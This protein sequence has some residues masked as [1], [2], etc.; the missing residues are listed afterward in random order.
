MV[1]HPHC[2][3]E[4]DLKG[5]VVQV[6]WWSTAC[7]E[8]PYWDGG[9]EDQRGNVAG[10]CD[11]GGSDGCGFSGQVCDFICDGIRGYGYREI[12]SGFG[13]VDGN[14]VGCFDCCVWLC[15]EA[16]VDKG[17]GDGCGEEGVRRR[18]IGVL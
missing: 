18:Q 14:N 15:D 17:R 8:G 6:W 12:A 7:V 16:C 13:G 1:E 5:S 10:E 4:G 2:E 3:G 9:G 11:N